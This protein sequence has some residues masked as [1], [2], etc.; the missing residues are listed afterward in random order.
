MEVLHTVSCHRFHIANTLNISCEL[1]KG[2]FWW[3]EGMRKLGKSGEMLRKGMGGEVV[4]SKGDVVGKI[5]K[6]CG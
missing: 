4:R 5:C 1:R 6:S 3:G 2:C